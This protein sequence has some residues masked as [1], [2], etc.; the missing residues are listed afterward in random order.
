MGFYFHKLKVKRLHL[1]LQVLWEATPLPLHCHTLSWFL[2]VVAQAGVKVG[3]VVTCLVLL[4][5]TTNH[6]L[7]DWERDLLGTADDDHP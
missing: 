6:E 4:C 2:R 3:V 7:G 1:T 5:C